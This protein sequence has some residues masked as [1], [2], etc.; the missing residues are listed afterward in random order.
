LT[1][2]LFWITAL[3]DLHGNGIDYAT[4]EGKT[5]QALGWARN[6]AAHELLTLSGLDLGSS[7]LRGAAIRGQM[8]RGAGGRVV[9]IDETALPQRQDERG[10]RT[11]YQS[12]VANRGALEPLAIVETFLKGLAVAAIQQTHERDEGPEVNLPPFYGRW[13][14]PS[15][16]LA[17]SVQ[18]HQF[19]GF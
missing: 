9:W 3:K 14:V 16:V 19:H 5:L 12:L 18:P 7:A 15:A 10:R 1:E 17:Q 13:E 4:T 2:A 11:L 8:V 6:Y